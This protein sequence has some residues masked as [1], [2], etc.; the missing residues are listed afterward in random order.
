MRGA[1]CACPDVGEPALPNGLCKEKTQEGDQEAQEVYD[2]LSLTQDVDQMLEHLEQH[3]HY[4]TGPAEPAPTLAEDSPMQGVSEEQPRVDPAPGAPDAGEGT[5]DD[6]KR[7]KNAL[8]QAAEPL[9]TASEAASSS[10]SGTTD[11]CLWPKA[12]AKT[13]P[14]S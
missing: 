12:K 13:Q 4:P 11:T 10:S 3:V 7:I 2:Q 9:G 5:A 8:E 14:A 1:W 6:R